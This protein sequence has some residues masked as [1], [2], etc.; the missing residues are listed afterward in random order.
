MRFLAVIELARKRSLESTVR[1]G[2]I[3]VGA[4]AAQCGQLRTFDA[5]VQF[6]GVLAAVV[7]SAAHKFDGPDDTGK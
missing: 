2:P 1:N 6:G 4:R 3:E 7:L 5:A